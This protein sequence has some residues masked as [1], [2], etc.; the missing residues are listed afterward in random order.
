MKP[1]DV[2]VVG[3]GIQGV[4]IALELARAGA[5]VH[6]FDEMAE[7]LA[8]TS[9]I[10][11]GKLHTGALYANDPSGRTA[12][13]MRRASL[14]FTPLITR[15]LGEPM[16]ESAFSEPF[17]Y[18]VHRDS[19]LSPEA[20]GG[21]LARVSEGFT[22]TSDIPSGRYPGWDSG[23][24]YET[25]P[26]R[27]RRAVYSDE[28]VA[29]F[30]TTE[31]AIDPV[32][33]AV[34]LTGAVT[35]EERIHLYLGNR[36]ERVIGDSHRMS[37]VCAGGT[38]GPYHHVVNAAW[39]GRLALDAGRGI[40]PTRPWLFRFKAGAHIEGADLDESTAPST[41]VVLGAFGDI[42]NRGGG[43]WYLS[44]YPVCRLGASDSLHP[45]FHFASE[46]LDECFDPM[47]DGLEELIP[48]VGKLRATEHRV[49]RGG[50][51]FA[52]GDGDIHNAETELHRRFEVGPASFGSYHS[53]DTG[54]LTT[55]P[56]FAMETARRILQT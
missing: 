52:W 36:V 16:P 4:C 9:R 43:R 15:W 39:G 46:A 53:V 42:V 37:L 32:V 21:H 48:A 38:H 25:V 11:E 29:A 3:A 27:T 2:A 30:R 51:I 23:P 20:V 31:R 28:I 10:G 8:A 1:R 47:I 18:A 12:A 13:L 44:W 34:L 14:S 50:V 5:R 55:A 40:V 45:G 7:P 56:L 26:T 33:L 41:T 54:K 35:D 17:W 19:L 49:M 24:F 6:L 22:D